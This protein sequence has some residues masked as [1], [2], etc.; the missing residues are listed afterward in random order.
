[1][2]CYFNMVIMLIITFNLLGPP[3]PLSFSLAFL[4][5]TSRLVFE[6]C[7]QVCE[8]QKCEQE[9]FPLSVQYLDRYLSKVPIKVSDLQLLGEV[10]MLLASKLKDCVPLTAKKLSIY[11]NHSIT[12]SKILVTT[13]CTKSK[14]LLS[15]EKHSYVFM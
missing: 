12:V 10:C 8:E 6:F 2:T 3:N 14:C 11:S 5:S 7:L 15:Q 9:V 1:M 4:G 13:C